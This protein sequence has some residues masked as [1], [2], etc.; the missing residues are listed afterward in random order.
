MQ[1]PAKQLNGK[2][3]G[4]TLVEVLLVISIIALL[5]SIAIPAY[6]R[7]RRRAQATHI[8]EDLRSI[9]SAIDQYATEFN[10]AHGSSVA[11]SD[12]QKYFKENSELYITGADIFGNTY[13]PFSVDSLPLINS[14]TYDA[15]SDAVDPAF[16]SPFHD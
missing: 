11:F 2:H 8:L 16:W 6:Q 15:L 14:N 5:A 12:L 7:S 13:G 3:G 9:D 1:S 4:F 10:K